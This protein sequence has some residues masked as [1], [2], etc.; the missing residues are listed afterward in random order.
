LGGTEQATLGGAKKKKIKGG[1][2]AH[3]KKPKNQTK[4]HCKNKEN[5][6]FHPNSSGEQKTLSIFP[7]GG[8]G[9]KNNNKKKTP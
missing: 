8:G 9:H 6:R 7:G 1:R 3:G 5:N 4:R 2:G